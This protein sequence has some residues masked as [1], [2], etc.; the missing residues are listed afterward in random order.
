M[1]NKIRS[2]LPAL[3]FAAMLLPVGASATGLDGKSNL[4]CAAVDVIGCTN[5]PGCREGTANSFGLPQFM[6]VDFNKQ[7]IQATDETGL[8]VISEIKS[9][10]ITEQQ[11]ILQGIENHRGWSVT[12]DRGDGQLTVASS[13]SGVSFMVFGACTAR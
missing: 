3:G 9:S 10:E 4:V 11:I 13:G 2:M 1:L 8:D 12:I 6:F 5:G 7:E